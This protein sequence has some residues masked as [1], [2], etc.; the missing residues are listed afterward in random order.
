VRSSRVALIGI[1]GSGK[2]TVANLLATQTG[3]V[4]LTSLRP[5]MQPHVAFH[6]LSMALSTASQLADQ[7]GNRRLKLTVLYLQMATLGPVERLLTARFTPAAVI[8]DRHALLDGAAYLPMLTRNLGPRRTVDDLGLLSRVDRSL[9]TAWA[10]SCLARTDG[11]ANLDELVDHLVVLAA[12]P[13]GE[14]VRVLGRWL[15]CELPDV[16]IL[17]DL[18]P[19]EALDRIS[20][21]DRGPE[22][23]ESAGA[24]SQVAIEYPRVLAGIGLPVHRIAVSGRTAQEVCAE[25]KRSVTWS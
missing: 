4:L 18:D 3:A 5:H 8:F 22:L 1:D 9:I 24:L 17:L 12:L 23:H 16:A 7:Q 13:A 11:P 19:T 25:A 20:K 15:D 10:D 21:R 2:T 6:D 14:L